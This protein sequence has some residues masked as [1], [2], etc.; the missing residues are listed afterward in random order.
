VKTMESGYAQRRPLYQLLWCFE[1]ARNT[2][3]HLEDT[4]RLCE[5]LRVPFAGRFG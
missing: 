2:S 1:Y 4:R 5:Q 3:E